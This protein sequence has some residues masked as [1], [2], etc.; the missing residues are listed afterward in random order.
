M[1]ESQ[2]TLARSSNSLTQQY[3]ERGARNGYTIYD[4]GSR[5]LFSCLPSSMY[6]TFDNGQSMFST[7]TT[8]TTT[9]GT[10]H[11]GTIIWNDVCCKSSVDRYTWVCLIPSQAL[12]L[13][14]GMKM[15][16]ASL[17]IFVSSDRACL[18]SL[19]FCIDLRFLINL[20]VLSGS[21]VGPNDPP[22]CVNAYETHAWNIIVN[23]RTLK[24]FVVGSESSQEFVL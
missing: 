6:L 19:F 21:L 15:K 2:Y 17:E 5:S 22:L 18:P 11:H 13:G 4:T 7:T 12:I 20:L 24:T 23:G 1:R 16:M 10:I 9:H 14:L 8:T 3:I